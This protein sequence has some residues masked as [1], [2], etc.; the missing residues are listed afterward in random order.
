M[1]LI[2]AFDERDKKRVLSLADCLAGVAPWAK[3]GLELFVSQGPEIIKEFKKRNFKIF[4][5][6]KFYDIPNTVAGA[7]TAAL[8]LGCDMLTLHV[9]AGERACAEAIRAAEKINP[10]ALLFGVTALTSFGP[11]EMPLINMEPGRVAL[12]LAAKAADWG[13]RGVVCSG[14]EAARIK[15][16][17]PGLLCL[18]PGIRPAG[19]A[20]QDQRRAVTPAAAVL[21]GAD[22]IVVGRP[23]TRAEEPAIAA[24][25]ILAQVA[26]ARA[27]VA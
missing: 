17:R 15:K 3:M 16:A 4:L 6:L 27:S 21:G 23:I 11:G 1:A 25:E 13:L 18:C 12:D 20:A 8:E 24:R 26:A 7:T 9:Q 19:V 10:E 5:D 2:V 14:E 22:F